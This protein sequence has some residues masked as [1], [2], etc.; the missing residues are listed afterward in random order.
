[1]CIAKHANNN[2]IYSYNPNPATKPTQ[3]KINMKEGESE[4]ER[5]G[6]P[7]CAW[8][9]RGVWNF[10]FSNFPLSGGQCPLTI[11]GPAV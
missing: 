9:E 7:A 2:I 6:K 4:K 8:G 5:E 1:M 11:W 10:S 3:N